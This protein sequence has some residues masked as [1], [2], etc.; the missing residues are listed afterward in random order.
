MN[1]IRKRSSISVGSELPFEAQDANRNAV[2]G[3]RSAGIGLAVVISAFAGGC[4]QVQPGYS[5][6]RFS[7]VTPPVQLQ[8]AELLGE[9]GDNDYADFPHFAPR[10]TGCI[11]PL[12]QPDAV[13]GEASTTVGVVP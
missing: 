5:W 11:S 12:V 9:V 3:R 2:S 13:D 1:E 4:A 10:R 7:K 6:E 8:F